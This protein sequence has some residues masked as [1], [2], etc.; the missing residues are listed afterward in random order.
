MEKEAVEVCFTRR[1]ARWY[2]EVKQLTSGEVVSSV[3]L[4]TVSKVTRPKEE[5]RILIK[6]KEAGEIKDLV[7]ECESDAKELSK[8]IRKVINWARGESLIN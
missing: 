6:H 2:L 3:N 5:K 4:L 1:L 8:K 7:V